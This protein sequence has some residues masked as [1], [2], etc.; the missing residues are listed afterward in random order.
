MKKIIIHLF[1]LLGLF[2]CG[3]H[4][5]KSKQKTTS[6]TEKVTEHKDSVVAVHEKTVETISKFGDTLQGSIVLN[7]S[8][9][10]D[11]IESGG[12]KILAQITSKA[13]ERRVKIKAIAKPKIIIQKNK[14]FQSFATKTE[15]H[16][17]LKKDSTSTVLRKEVKANP[18]KSGFT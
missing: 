10:C 16:E 5:S 14:E 1:V 17:D 3:R 4:V 15:Y 12:I 18:L 7:D 11:S 9:T 13:G 2:S 6:S 8:V